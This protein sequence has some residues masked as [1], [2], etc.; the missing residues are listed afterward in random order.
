[1]R[2]YYDDKKYYVKKALKVARKLNN[3][4]D[5]EM[6]KI[7]LRKENVYSIEFIKDINEEKIIDVDLF[8]IENISEEKHG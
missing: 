5:I 8:N 6:L 7:L 4:K 2:P 3:E 1:M